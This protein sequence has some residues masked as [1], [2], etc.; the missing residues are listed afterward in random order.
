MAGTLLKSDVM[1]EAEG[2]VSEDAYIAAQGGSF[3]SS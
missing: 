1:T 2:A 3:P